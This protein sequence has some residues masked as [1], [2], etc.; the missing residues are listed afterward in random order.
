MLFGLSPKVAVPGLAAIVA[1]ILLVI[2]GAVTNEATVT[3][4]GLAT[5]ATGIGTLGLGSQ[6]PPA[7]GPTITQAEVQAVADN[8][9]LRA[10]A[11]RKVA[12]TR[13]RT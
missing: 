1:G 3:T 8:P 7:V 13:R 12:R 10:E 11:K 9:Q 6:L 2:I 5:I 4:A